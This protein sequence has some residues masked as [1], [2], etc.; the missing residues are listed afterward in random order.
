MSLVDLMPTILEVCGNKQPS[1][2]A[3]KSLVPF[4]KGKSSQHRDVVFFERER[5]ANVRKGNAS[6]PSRGVRTNEFLYIRNLQHDQWPAG[7]PELWFA[8]G[9]YGDVDDGLTKSYILNHQDA[10]NNSMCY[11]PLNFAKRPSEELYD[12]KKDPYQL[13]NLAADNKFQSEKDKLLSLL[14]RWMKETDDPRLKTSRD[15]YSDYK[16]YGPPLKN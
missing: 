12:L 5:H 6:Y 8:V 2:L 9:P 13:N 7:D 1:G 11:Y 14:N 15:I 3:G 10:C 16:Y 4:F